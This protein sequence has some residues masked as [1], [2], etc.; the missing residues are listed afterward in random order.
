MLINTNVLPL[1]QT[2][3]HRHKR[4]IQKVCSLTQKDMV[5]AFE[6]LPVFSISQ[7]SVGRVQVAGATRGTP[8]IGLPQQVWPASVASVCIPRRPLDRDRR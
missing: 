5:N 3:I 2:G 6:I 4:G 7:F 8:A 1:S